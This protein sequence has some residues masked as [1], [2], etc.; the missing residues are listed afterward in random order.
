MDI[1][2]QSMQ[3]L[4]EMMKNPNETN[5]NR[6]NGAIKLLQTIDMDEVRESFR[7]L[8]I[9]SGDQKFL[10]LVELVGNIESTISLATLALSNCR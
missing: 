7:L 1:M 3:E 2:E 4:H 10:S 5:R 6:I 9:K 8:W